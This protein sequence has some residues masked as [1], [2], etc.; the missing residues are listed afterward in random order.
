MPL[1]SA[2][3]VVFAG[4]DYREILKAA[5]E[6]GDIILWDGGNNDFPFFR[7]DLEITVTDPLRGGDETSYF[8]GEVNLRRAEVV[9]INKVNAA[10]GKEVLELEKSIGS[11]NRSAALIRTASRISVSDGD[12]IAGKRVLVIEDGPSITHGGLPSGAGLAAAG[13]ELPKRGTTR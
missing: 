5:E 7:P 12:E 9:I 4:I 13:I 1:I 3:A 11:I 6:E 10:T 8:P 2:G